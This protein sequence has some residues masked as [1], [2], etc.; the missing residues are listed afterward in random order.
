MLLLPQ[1]ACYLLFPAVFV[2]VSPAS[3]EN[4]NFCKLSVKEELQHFGV[5]EGMGMPRPCAALCSGCGLLVR[6]ASS[7]RRLLSCWWCL[8]PSPAFSTSLIKGSCL[9]FN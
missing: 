1:R 4:T 2:M 3:R 7:R 5:A 8:S 6:C 9:L